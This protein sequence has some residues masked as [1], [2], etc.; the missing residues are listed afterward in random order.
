MMADDGGEGVWLQMTSLLP[1]L[2]GAELYDFLPVL[3]LNFDNT[4]TEFQ[5][6][7]S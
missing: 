4:E 3:V 2:I 6:Y 7:D 1:P 5:T